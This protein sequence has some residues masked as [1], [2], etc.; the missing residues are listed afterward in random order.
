MTQNIGK[1]ARCGKD[2]DAFEGSFTYKRLDVGV[3][4]D[5]CFT[6]QEEYDTY[7]IAHFLT[8]GHH[9]NANE[10]EECMTY[11]EF[12]AEIEFNEEEE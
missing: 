12:N 6:P 8:T 7:C 4:C 1:C 11:E 10:C 5:E 2:L 3:V 9:P